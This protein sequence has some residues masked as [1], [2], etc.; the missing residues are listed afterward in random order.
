LFPRRS[1][2]DD[3]QP[4]GDPNA[5]VELDGPNIEAT[6]SGDRAQPRSHRPLGIVLMRPRV[7]EIGQNAL[8]HVLDNSA[9]EPGNDVGNGVVIGGDDLA[10][11]LGIEARRKRRRAD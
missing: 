8:T 10:Q 5:G 11:I 4:G 6:D 7:A 2:T 1:F 3:H 9:I